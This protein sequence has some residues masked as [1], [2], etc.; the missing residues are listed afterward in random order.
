[1]L[2]SMRDEWNMAFLHSGREALGYLEENTVDVIVSDLRM[3]EMT[4]AEL[5]TNVGR[6]Y[7]DTVR[8]MLSGYAED[9]GIYKSVGP[10][11]CIISPSFRTTIRSAIVIAST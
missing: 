1:M 8:I 2:R 9:A 4:G 5:L 7:P 10:S 3:S 6:L 11:T